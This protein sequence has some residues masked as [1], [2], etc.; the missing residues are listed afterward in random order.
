MIYYPRAN[1]AWRRSGRKPGARVTNCALAKNLAKS[2]VASSRKGGHYVIFCEVVV[3]RKKHYKNKANDY[4][5][6][7]VSEP[8]LNFGLFFFGFFSFYK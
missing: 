1:G 4:Y 6:G 5:T 7:H 8:C 3:E 2:K